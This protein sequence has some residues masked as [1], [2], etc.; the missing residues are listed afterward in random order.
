MTCQK[1]AL[2][3]VSCKT[4]IIEFAEELI[5]LDWELISTGGT[6]KVLKEAGLTVTPIEEVT[7][8]PE[9]LDGRV[10]TLSFQVE[11]ALLYDRTNPQHVETAKEN[12]IPNISLVVCNLYPFKETIKK[13]EVTLEEAIEQIDIGGPT[14][15]RSAAKN[16]KSVTVVI[17]PNDYFSIIEELKE[18]NNETKLETRAKFAVK[19][20]DHTADYDASID[21]YLSKEILNDYKIRLKFN[22]GKKLRYGENWH[23]KANY[24]VD[25][26]VEEPNLPMAKQLHGK[27]LSFNNFIDGNSALEAIKS[28]GGK[29]AVCV[30]KHNN[31]CGYATGETLKEALES[32]WGGDPVSAFGS[33]VA[34]TKKIDLKT[35][36]FF[37]D[38]FVEI[39][40]APGFDIDA[41]E[42]LKVKSKNLRLLEIPPVESGRRRKRTYK[43]LIGGILEQERDLLSFEKWENSTKT[44]LPEEK[45][46]LAEFSWL[47]VQYVKSNAVVITEE[48]KKG[49]FRTLSI[50][51][52]QPNR[53][54]AL[55][56]IA[57]PNAHAHLKLLYPEKYTKEWGR[58]KLGECVMSSDAFFPFGDTVEYS[59]EQGLKYIIQPGGSIRDKD[60][61][62]I[63]NKYNIAM[64]FTNTRHFNH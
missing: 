57:I 31:P 11:G 8:N 27:E 44:K 33:V 22:K 13:K 55:E 29:T 28:L 42:Y 47:S 19:V 12:N 26:R 46:A 17:D 15:I 2:L 3:S 58:E 9:I 14:M 1:K 35:A 6:Y 52:G 60:S 43:H 63:C 32:A 48:Y 30:V 64:I 41:L 21:K 40:L 45:R 39:I 5:K 4:G 18:N 10:K 7:K 51:A 54:D 38:K 36:E 37:K 53:I 50:G 62:D 24:F 20:F 49:Y 16:Y 25:S 34:C 59:H 23:Q 56:K 61:I